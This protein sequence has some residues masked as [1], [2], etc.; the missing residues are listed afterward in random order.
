MGS[1]N[2][3]MT[4]LADAIREKALIVHVPGITE[5]LLSIDKM[6]QVVNEDIYAPKDISS[7]DAEPSDVSIGV[8]YRDLCE[9]IQQHR[10]L[11]CSHY[12]A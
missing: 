8:V 6:I 2:D 7:L 1:L 5:N 10:G 11:P 4:E 9:D 3:K 12:P